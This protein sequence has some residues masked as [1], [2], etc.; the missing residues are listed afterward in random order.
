MELYEEFDSYVVPDSILDGVLVS[1]IVETATLFINA[2]RKT[3]VTNDEYTKRFRKRSHSS[4]IDN[5]NIFPLH[6]GTSHRTGLYLGITRLINLCELV[7]MV[8]LRVGGTDT[9]LGCEELMT[10][11]HNQLIQIE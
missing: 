4:S 6:G 11:I 8:S 3:Y 5:T 7:T 10:T 2:D 1:T 9:L